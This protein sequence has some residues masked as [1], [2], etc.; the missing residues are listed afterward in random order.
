MALPPI[1]HATTRDGVGIAFHTVG[2]GPA[3]VMLFPYHVNHLA[4]NWQVPLHRGAIEFFAR[5]FTVVNLD[6]RGAGLSARCVDRLSLATFA[7][8]LDAV[9]TILRLDRV[10]LVAVGP[11]TLIACHVAATSP[12]CVSCLISIEGG[13]SEANRRVL[14][15]RHVSP[16]VE[17]NMRGALVS[18]ID[19]RHSAAAL[20][21]VARA[22]LQSDA[23]QHWEAILDGSDL[24]AIAARVAAP[25]LYVRVAD[26]EVIPLS[27]AQALVERIPNATLITVPGRSPIDVW[28]DRAGNQYMARFVAQHFGVEADVVRAQRQERKSRVVHPKG[29]S[30]REVEVLRLLAAGKSNQHIADELFI[31]LNTVSH[32]LRNIFAKTGT[33][34]RTEAAS[35]AHH[36][37]LT[38]ENGPAPAND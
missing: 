19:D 1:H 32:H 23:L 35:F 24:L 20:A 38:A 33:V 18:G 8:D 14:S 4:L 11:A 30:E 5:Y 9:L 7:E 28:R 3:V 16:H 6:F 17:A 26:D 2:D 10:A 12:D 34:N 15:L 25:M 29:L 31:S 22:A 37:G 27:A 13:T 36:C 21:A